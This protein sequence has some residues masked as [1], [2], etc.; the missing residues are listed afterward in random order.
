MKKHD[1]VK[2]KKTPVDIVL[3]ECKSDTEI[4]FS[5][6][7]VTYRIYRAV[8]KE[9]DS[10]VA[11]TILG[12]QRERTER[13]CHSVLCCTTLPLDKRG[14]FGS[15]VVQWVKITMW[16][17]TQEVCN[18]NKKSLYIFDFRLI[19]K[20]MYP[21]SSLPEWSPEPQR[22]LSSKEWFLGSTPRS[23]LNSVWGGF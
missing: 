21:N 11:A 1:L 15:S 22:R 14:R 19:R 4:Q 6:H 8:C 23:V 13:H 7:C 5:K 20:D 17:S 18:E 9:V 3:I 2:K 12:K 16:S 10:R